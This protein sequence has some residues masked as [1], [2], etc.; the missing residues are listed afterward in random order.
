MPP[1]D[2]R[3][4]P[5]RRRRPQLDE[6]KRFVV[7]CEGKVTEPQYLKALARLPEVRKTA[8]LDIHGLGLD[9]KRSVQTLKD[10]R[11]DI[12]SAISNPCFELWLVLHHVDHKR[13]LTSPK[14]QKMRHDHDGSEGRSLQPD[15]Y[16][17]RKM[18]A[19]TRARELDR[20]HD[21]AG[22]RLPDN[23]PSSGM[24]KLLD[25]IFQTPA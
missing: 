15:A 10:F 11:N 14:S 7:F 8:S 23:N 3:P 1:R 16:M 12:C 18:E 25:S 17:Q 2:R 13:W 5:L 19:V 20:M 4:K 6:K 22:R 24:F 21:Q 9:P